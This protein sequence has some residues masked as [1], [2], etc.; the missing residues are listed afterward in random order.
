MTAA[1]EKDRV[2][3]S[4]SEVRTL[5]LGA[6][7]LL[8]FQ[9]RASFEQGFPS[10]SPS[11]QR[12]ELAALVLLVVSTA[13]MIAPAPYHR[14]VSG[15]HATAAMERYT[16]RMALLALVPFALA[17]GTNFGVTLA[18]QLGLFVACAIGLAVIVAAL[19][20]WFGPALAKRRSGSPKEDEM[21]STK[22]RITEL[23]TE[24]RIILP[25]VQALL[26]FQFASYLT[27]AFDKLSPSAKVVNTG[28]LFLLVL[29]MVLL[30]MLAPYHRLAEGGENTERFEQVA[31]RL[32]LAALLPL[33]LGVAG[34]VFV[35]TDVVLGT[36]AGIA[37]ALACAVGMAALWIGIPL[38]AAR[39]NSR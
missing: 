24:A 25:G 12:L 34:D 26:G 38:L 9:Y 14:I 11:A 6:Q 36:R 35:V 15:G 27:P 18:R 22:E 17:L 39:R 13:C 33:A 28:S 7:I 20:C 10:L 37:I 2:K 4:L 23:L 29:A 1:T 5:V 31:E 32:V 21:V 3:T 16:K 19:L 8:G 30:M